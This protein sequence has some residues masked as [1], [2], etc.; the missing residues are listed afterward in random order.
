MSD[1]YARIPTSARKTVPTA[2]GFK[3]TGIEAEVCSWEGKIVSKIEWKKWMEEDGT[4]THKFIFEVRMEP[5][6]GT[7][8]SLLLATGVVGDKD[9]A[10][11]PFTFE[12]GEA[13]NY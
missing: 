9:T 6:H 12:Y 4:M 2:R 3:S 8:D 5:H 1:L 7:G 10:R 11:A 13:V